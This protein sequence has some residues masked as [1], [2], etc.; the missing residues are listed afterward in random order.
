[1]YAPE[2]K[3]V[4]VVGTFND[5]RPTDDYFM[6]R[7]EDGTWSK[8]IRLRPGGYQYKFIVDDMWIEDENNPNRVDD[9]FGGR[10]SVLEIN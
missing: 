1:M 7:G 10:N 9:T 4:R 8:M 6:E 2:A 5:W 3:S